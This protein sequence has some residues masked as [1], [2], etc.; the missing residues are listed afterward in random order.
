MLRADES[1]LVGD[2]V[3]MIG[4]NFYI[5][6]GR[7]AMLGQNFVVTNGRAPC[8][9]SSAKWNL[10]TNS[11]F[12]LR[13][14]KTMEYLDRFGRSQDHLD[15]ASLQANF[16]ANKYYSPCNPHTNSTENITSRWTLD[17]SQ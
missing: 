2:F 9:A 17:R 7:R 12:T 16:Q 5:N 1:S 11:A 15:T 4:L 10:S 3:R 6:V 14:K 8:E 13:P